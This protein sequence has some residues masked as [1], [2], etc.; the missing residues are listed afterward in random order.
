MT[1]RKN[2]QQDKMGGLQRLKRMEN[3]ANGKLGKCA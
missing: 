2:K 3:L 1:E